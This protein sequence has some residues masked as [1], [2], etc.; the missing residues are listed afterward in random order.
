MY[1]LKIDS[2]ERLVSLFAQELDSS[3]MGAWPYV[4]LTAQSIGVHVNRDYGDPT[5]EEDM[6]GHEIVDI[7]PK[8]A[9]E[10]FDVMEHYIRRRPIAQADVLFDA[11]RRPKPFARF[12]AEVQ[13]LGILQD[14]YNYKNAAFEKIAEARLRDSGIDVR[15]GKIV[16]TIPENV[17]VFK[18]QP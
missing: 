17:I 9:R 3:N 16:C 12:R 18:V 5:C 7:E 11:I 15:D 4:D 10:S 14:W 8:G 2:W 13:R 1:G 6:D